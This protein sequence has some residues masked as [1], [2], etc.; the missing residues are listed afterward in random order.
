MALV[1]AVSMTMGL[2][3][4][5][6]DKKKEKPE[7]KATAAVE[8]GTAKAGGR[9]DGQSDV[10]LVA[11]SASFDKKFNPFLAS[12]EADRQ[13][14]DLT[15]TLLVGNDRAGKIVYKG[16]D[17]ELR[18]Y[19]D[20]NYTYFGIA[21]VKV[22]YRKEKDRTVYRIKLRDDLVFS[23]GEPLNIDD[24]IFSIYAFCDTDY[25]GD[26]SLGQKNIQGLLNYQANSSVAESLSEGQVDRYLRK[27]PKEL[28]K[29]ID[30]QIIRKTLRDG[31][32]Q[33]RENYEEAGFAS[34]AEY[35]IAK[36]SRDP[37]KRNETDLKKA[38]QAVVREYDE[39]NYT[40]LAKA[41]SGD[42][43]AFD[44]AIRREARK[45]LARSRQKAGKAKKVKNISGIR[46]LNDYEMKIITD[47]YDKDMIYSLQIPVCA[48]H[49]YGDRTKYNYQKN[50]F[51]F[52]RG[53]IS[54]LQANR[55]SP[56]GAGAYRF[57]K[58]ESGIV[59]YTSNELYYQ[60]CP[61]VAYLQLKD[62]SGI[63]SEVAELQG[64][65]VDLITASL[66]QEGMKELEE[67]NSNGEVSG[68]TVTTR[69]VKENEYAYIGLNARNVK[70][71]TNGGSEASRNLRKAL[72]TVLSAFRDT[73][74]AYYGYGASVINY[75]V[76][77]DSWLSPEQ[78]E[79]GSVAYAVDPDGEEI[80][81]SDDDPEE[82]QEKAVQAALN[83]LELAGYTI[84][85]GKVTA[86]PAG[87]SLEYQIS[88]LGGE[89]SPM[90]PM[91]SEAAECLANMGITLKP[92][93][94]GDQVTFRK[95]LLSGMVQLWCG[96]AEITAD[97]DFYER[98][99]RDNVV[100]LD[101]TDENLFHI[102]DVALDQAMK[103]ADNSQ[104]TKDRIEAADKVYE[105]IRDWGVE[106]PVYQ[107]RTSLLL[108]TERID[109]DTV[110][111]DITPYYGWTQEIQDI[112]MK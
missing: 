59:Y 99:G 58:Y 14:V 66:N 7:P 42:E 46:R 83:Y 23:D 69:F 30:D 21:D 18:E 63:S 111:E 19:N 67:I 61:K 45:Q 86:A 31:M 54:A 62:M 95:N 85:N 89:S 24:V 78:R 3:A 84:D 70:V 72:T 110:M 64:K 74:K 47:G 5:G 52:K 6:K 8:N 100:N 10:P 104:K 82:K 60:G 26:V 32:E 20:T 103:K 44:T 9:G 68:K 22:R 71:G 29:W 81:K 15:Q 96:V 25:Q 51:G 34:A 12:S 77:A 93:S 57:V 105:I 16:I 106:L 56:M 73:A 92:V 108:S 41:D 50:Q 90:Y 1:L 76:S 91:I 87:A 38:Y 75:P 4:C 35:F 49:Y 13:A 94:V 79:Q 37:G 53:D 98:Y 39:R 55:T 40:L 36:Y 97:L 11:A 17:G 43:N 107:K 101:G 28:Q 27:M 112:E 2:T 48:L 33:S 88:I 102:T 80:Y 65:T 109:V